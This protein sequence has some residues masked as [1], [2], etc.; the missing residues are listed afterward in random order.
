MKSVAVIGASLAGLSAARALR[1]QGFDGEL[2]IVGGEARRPYDRPPL[3]KEFLAGVVG[4]DDLA[5]E[6]DDEDLHANWLLGVHA[7]RLDAAAGAVV[8]DDGT[9]IRAD[10]VV[11]ATGARA[12]VWPGAEGLAGVHVLR[13]IDD[14]L[15]L[16]D[17]LRPGVRLAVIGAGFIGAEVAST[18]RK[19]GL[20]VTVVEA[21][22]TPL[23]GPL[24]EQLGA[25]VARLHAEH[26][27]RLLCGVGVAGLTGGDRVTGVE[28]ADGRRLPADVVRGRYRRG[29]QHRVAARRPARIGRRRGVRRGRGDVD[30]ECRCGGRLFGLA[31]GLRR[32]AAPRRTLD[33]GAGA[34]GHRGRHAACRG[35]Y[36]GT[37]ARPP[38]FWS[39]QYGSRIQFAGIA[40]PH[41]EITFEVGSA[42][43][44]S[45]LAVYRRGD[46]PVAVLGVDQ[47]RL[48]TRW[49]RQLGSV[50]AAS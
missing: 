43:D 12:R 7:S 3:S 8:L 48:F 14:A 10:G 47:P 38:Y 16:R 17:E 34:A 15:A 33:R 39:D 2:T 41:D 19:L 20:D 21:A 45:F 9:T 18:A 42:D 27:T 28:L 30:P 44:A 31:R 46:R 35:R 11:V 13:T 23:A 37:P 29:A 4:E 25:A 49:R 24:G 6:S 40:G 36:Q 50:P 5:L 32:P 26:G 1:D 22:P